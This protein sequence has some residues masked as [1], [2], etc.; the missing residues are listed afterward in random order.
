MPCQMQLKAQGRHAQIFTDL[1]FSTKE[2]ADDHRNVI[3]I[4]TK[5]TILK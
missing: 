1:Y 2:S 5:S 4:L 3:D